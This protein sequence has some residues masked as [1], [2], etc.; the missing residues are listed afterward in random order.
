VHAAKTPDRETINSAL[1]IACRAPSVLNTQPWRWAVANHSA[2]LFADPS[3]RLAVL[4]PQ[5]RELTI[6]CGAALHHARIGFRAMG[7]RP[8]VHRLPNPA[9]RDHLASIEF[10]PLPRI[11]QQ[12]LALVAASAVRRTDR[13]P[14]LPTPVPAHL[15]DRIAFAGSAEGVRVTLVNQPSQRHEVIVALAQADSRRRRDPMYQAE[16]GEWTQR[17]LSAVAGIPACG[18]PAAAPLNRDMRG[19]DLRQGELEIPPPM[20]DGAMLC[21]LSTSTDR[22]ADWLRT[23]EALSAMLLSAAKSHLATCTL[24]HVAKVREAH[25]VARRVALGATGEPQLVLRVGWP[26]TTEFPGPRTP[27]RA[28]HEVVAQWTDY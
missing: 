27:R 6:S 16:L 25:D 21:V 7:W 19:R 11:D 2:H 18:V 23:G 4:D 17:R 14:F 28:P 15:L 22:E 10:S 20:D 12:A 1:E 24:S 26:V 9:R 13:G 8:V 5:G 3:R